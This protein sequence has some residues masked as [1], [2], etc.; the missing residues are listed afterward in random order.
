VFAAAAT[1]G[2][3][4]RDRQVGLCELVPRVAPIPLLRP[5]KLLLG[6]ARFAALRRARP[7]VVPKL[8]I[9]LSW[10]SIAARW[11]WRRSSSSRCAA[12]AIR[13]ASARLSW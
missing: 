2:D 3:I 12:S 10:E 6:S 5:L 13:L 9:S 11:A 4:N 7:P 8:R 1:A